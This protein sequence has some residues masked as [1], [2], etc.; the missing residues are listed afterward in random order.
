MAS[1]PGLNSCDY[2]MWGVIEAD[3]NAVTHDSVDDLKDVMKSAF[4]SNKVTHVKVACAVFRDHTE[5]VVTASG[6]SLCDLKC[7]PEC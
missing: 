1:S 5:E 7:I 3:P 6:D 4:V 2:W